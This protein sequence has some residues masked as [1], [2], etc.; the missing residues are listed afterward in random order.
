MLVY[1]FRKAEAERGVVQE[2]GAGNQQEQRAGGTQPGQTGLTLGTDMPGQ[3]QQQ[4]A[5]SH[6]HRTRRHEL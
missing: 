6:L 1:W 2:P 5:A 4:H 3:Q